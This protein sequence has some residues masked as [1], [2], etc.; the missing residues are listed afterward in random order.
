ME[1]IEPTP[2]G[3]RGT[4]SLRLTDLIQM[5]CL[6]R[7]DLIIDVVSHKGKGTIHIRQGQINH[8]QTDRLTGEE[9]FF[10]VL[11]WNDGQFEIL[12]YHESGINS[13]NKPWEY[14][15]LEA[16]RHNDEGPPSAENGEGDG[17]PEIELS[18]NSSIGDLFDEIGDVL[19]DMVQLGRS[20]PEPAKAQPSASVSDQPIRVLLVDDSSFFSKQLK[21]MLEGD[22][23]IQVLSVARNG[24]E[25]LEF[26]E[27]K[28]PIDLITLDAEM[29]VM[30]GE[31]AL[32]HIMI[33]HH[34]PAVII[35]SLQPQSMYKV[36]DF[37]QL[38]A[39]DFF[40]KPEARENRKEYEVKLRRLVRG[41][42]KARISR[43]RRLRKQEENA[44]QPKPM[45]AMSAKRILLVVG[46]EGA[47]MDWFRMPLRELCRLGLVVG[48]QKLPENFASDFVG[49]IGQKT[50]VATERIT[51]NHEMVPGTFY[52]G[53]A[54]HNARL[55]LRLD[56]S[57]QELE[58][59]GADALQ[60]QTGMQLWVDRLTEQ[61][62]NC[63]DVYFLSS[64]DPLPESLMS[65]LL[66]RGIRLILAPPGSVLCSQLV[67]SVH[68]Y[69][70]HFT[71]QIICAAPEDL[72]E[73]L[74][75]Q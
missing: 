9:A 69:A 7:S 74:V 43:F 54:C 21:G 3:F 57:F 71:D 49:R 70:A 2:Q 23:T 24:K 13:V 48:L 20:G 42:A 64:I 53:N 75:K 63:I 16:V 46:A 52:L 66:D 34:L 17:G 30:P 41:A 72:P 58:I 12:P 11:Q 45:P 51:P 19:G 35:S 29:P 62:Q 15:L 18:G 38:G 60:W 22:S 28:T 55:Q 36:F 73:V 40:P 26:L 39:V 10:E 1:P 4:I 61:F 27:S 14:L 6:S 5:V 31:T 50:G 32:K 68:P 59:A 67:D 37:L 47:H 44:E 65:K 25:A 33:R 8:A 56:G